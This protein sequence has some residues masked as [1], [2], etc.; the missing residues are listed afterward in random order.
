MSNFIG[1]RIGINDAKKVVNGETKKDK[2]K[3]LQ[4]LIFDRIIKR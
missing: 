1:K 4:R 3:K 2:R